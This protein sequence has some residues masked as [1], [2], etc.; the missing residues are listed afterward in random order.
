MITTLLN[1]YFK[2]RIDEIDM[3]S[4][5][6]ESIQKQQLN[7]IL[8]K[9]K[10]TEFGE[11]YKF[12]DIKS[13]EKFCERIPIFSYET[14]RTY[15]DRMVKGEP[16]LLWPGKIEY[17]AQSSGTTGSKSKYIPV[18][19]ESFKTMHYKGG[20]DT[21]A[22][23]LNQNP[24]SKFFNGKSLVIGA[25]KSK[26]NNQGI[27]TGLLSGLLN[28]L[29]NPVLGLYKEP[30]HKTCMIGDFDEKMEK[31]L[32][33]IV[34]KN[35]V[36]ISGIPSWYQIL[37]YRL[38]EYVNKQNIT[39]IWPNLEVFF[40]GGVSFEPYK[41]LFK[42]FIPSSKMHYM[43]VFNASEG[44]FAIQN[45]LKDK[46]M[47]LMLD[48]GTYYE[49]IPLENIED[50]QPKALPIWEVEKGKSYAMLV[51][52]NSGLWRYNIGDVVT[53]TSIKPYKIII[54][55][56]TKHYLNLCG[57]EVMVSNADKAIAISCE[58]TGA[59]VLNYTASVVCSTAT[60]K[61][62]HQWMIEFGKKPTSMEDF[63]LYL[64]QTLCDIN[65]DYESKRAKSIALSIPEIIV[66][67][68]GLFE[69]WMKING[70]TNAQQ[71]IPRLQQNREIIEQ[72]IKLNY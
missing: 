5:N 23:Y 43:E 33:E 41:D 50:E 15:I 18:S 71:K 63:T 2:K 66:A 53:F 68:K 14:L 6:V 10:F 55:G 34:K 17:F 69:D 61:A 16:N 45:D 51:S 24:E 1:Q 67:R 20:A 60:I 8:E 7:S 22:L 58:K 48:Y 70:K 21:V 52:N 57:E 54:S 11:K 36:S 37:F 49:F 28:E 47:L 72:L 62:R 31:M 35:I 13:A 3:F 30:T 46:G 26:V 56:R 59:T 65:S 38:L 25:G 9:A 44:F 40:H 4:I 27:R 39:E 64:D 29:S 12:I 32:P 42:S 19:K